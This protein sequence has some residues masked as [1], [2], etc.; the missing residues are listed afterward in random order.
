LVDICV[1]DGAI[2]GALRFYE[3]DLREPD[4][5]LPLKAKLGNAIIINLRQ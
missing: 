3:S 2:V 1:K 4:L 5:I